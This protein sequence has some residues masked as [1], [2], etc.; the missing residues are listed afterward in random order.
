MY[1]HIGGDLVV[2]KKKLIAVIDLV[3]SQSA[4]AT[5]EFLEIADS[6]GRIRSTKKSGKNKSCIITED[7]VYLSTISASTITKRLKG[8]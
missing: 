2:P 4:P 1:L 6:E 3:S 8:E 5:Q 7:A